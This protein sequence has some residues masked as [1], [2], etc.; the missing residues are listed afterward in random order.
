MDPMTGLADFEE[1]AR[2]RAAGLL[3]YG[4]VLTGNE[5]DAADLV[6]E[7]LVRLGVR[8][9][10]VRRQDDPVGYVRTTMARLYVSWWRRRRRELL[11]GEVPD[12]PRSDDPVLDDRSGLW[13][14]LL[15]LP[16][17]QRAV[18]VLRYYE[19]CDDE[20]IASVLGISRGTVRS[21]AARGLAR[22][23]ESWAGADGSTADLV[24]EPK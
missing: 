16:P 17:R 19:V 6:Q 14:A 8:W 1:F 2:V 4:F 20:E 3:R 5:H 7:A 9:A 11:V 21:Q 15:R 24:K 23:R 18:L 10:R 13:P 12:R 22:L